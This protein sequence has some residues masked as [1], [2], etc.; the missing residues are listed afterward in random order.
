MTSSISSHDIIIKSHL[1]ILQ[2]ID[3]IF[4][5]GISHILFLF[6]EIYGNNKFLQQE[7]KA[8]ICWSVL[9]H[10]SLNILSHITEIVSLDQIS[11]HQIDIFF[12]DAGLSLRAALVEQY[13]LAQERGYLTFNLGSFSCKSTNFSC[14]V[15][16]R[17]LLA[18]IIDSILFLYLFWDS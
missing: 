14:S 6:R 18:L 10:I 8:S 4:L 16:P 1:P 15:S 7:T 9:D 17:I 2:N 3:S 12:F 5:P 11:V 13:L